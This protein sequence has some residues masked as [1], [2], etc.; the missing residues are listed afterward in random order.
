MP[1]N[2]YRRI[3]LAFPSR[4][5]HCVIRYQRSASRLARP[6]QSAGVAARWNVSAFEP[7]ARSRA[8]RRNGISVKFPR[9]RAKNDQ[10]EE[11]IAGRQINPHQRG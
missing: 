3:E 11:E 1:R 4:T 10:A 9:E 2:F 8:L 5:R 6:R 7:K